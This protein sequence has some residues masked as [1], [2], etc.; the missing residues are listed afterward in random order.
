MKG[1]RI[2]GQDFGIR[3]LRDRKSR[4]EW[5]GREGIAD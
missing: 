3:H 4:K 2:A 5:G 1:G